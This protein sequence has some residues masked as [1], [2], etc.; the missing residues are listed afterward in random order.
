M[1]TCAKTALFLVFTA[2]SEKSEVSRS[3]KKTIEFRDTG[4][5]SGVC[6]PAENG[7]KSTCLPAR[8]IGDW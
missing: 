5:Q 7:L 2:Y 8:I 6:T 1:A 3:Y 4:W